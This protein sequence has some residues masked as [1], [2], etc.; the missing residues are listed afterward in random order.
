MSE[1]ELRCP[2][3]GTP[4]TLRLPVQRSSAEFCT[5]CDH[6]LFWVPELDGVDIDATDPLV[7]CAACTHVNPAGSVFC[8]RCGQPV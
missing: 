8:N 5:A 1:L 7:S 4:A 3:C 6:P 2:T